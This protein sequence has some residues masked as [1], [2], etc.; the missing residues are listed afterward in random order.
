LRAAG[1]RNDGRWL[2][3]RIEQ[4]TARRRAAVNSI[5]VLGVDM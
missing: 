2:P 4:D 1:S 3:I 5:G